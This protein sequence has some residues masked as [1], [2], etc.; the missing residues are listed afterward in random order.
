MSKIILQFDE[1]DPDDRSRIPK[2]VAYYNLYRVIRDLD[3][4]MRNESKH[5]IGPGSYTPDEVRN[6]LSD[7]IKSND[8][9][10]AV[11]S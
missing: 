1:D 10:G 3:E 11:W 2:A 7:I 8:A 4:R 5:G 9:E 6:M